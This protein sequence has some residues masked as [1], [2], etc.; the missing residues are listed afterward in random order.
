MQNIEVSEGLTIGGAEP[1]GQ[2]AI[3]KLQDQIIAPSQTLY[4][5]NINGS[6]ETGEGTWQK[7]I[8]TIDRAVNALNTQVSSVYI[9]LDNSVP[10]KTY[11]MTAIDYK[12]R[13]TRWENLN[14]SVTS[15][16]SVVNTFNLFL[17]K[18]TEKV[19][20][21]LGDVVYNSIIKSNINVQISSDNKKIAT[22]IHPLY[23][24]VT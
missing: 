8:R 7:P 5:D 1:L 21:D 6:D 11:E 15:W 14:I 18:E 17:D 3:D 16:D 9:I 2:D 23:T 20:M 12:G 13:G 4:I 24:N 22:G 19:P 10:R